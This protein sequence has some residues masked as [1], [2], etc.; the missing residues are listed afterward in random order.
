MLRKMHGLPVLFAGLL[1]IVLTISGAVLSLAPAIER[2]A[3][4]IPAAG[5][6][7]VAQLAERVVTH[8][9]GVEQIERRPSGEVIVYFSADG[10]AGADLVDPL[11]GQAVAPYRPSALFRWVTDLHRAFLLNDAGRM[12]V[13]VM[14]ALMVLISVSGLFLL[15]RRAGGWLN[16]FRPFT[17]SG[18]SRIHAELARFAVLGL[19]LSALTGSYLSAVRFGLLPEGESPEPSFP[20]QVS[21]GQPAPVGGLI[22]L[23]GLDLGELQELVF[24]YPDDVQDVYSLTTKQGAGFVD[25]S[26]GELLQYQQRSANN[27]FQQWMVRLHTGEGLWWLAL[28][29]GLAALTV[30]VLSFTGLQL[31]WQRR[32]SLQNHPCNTDVTLAD[33]IILVGSEGNNTW[34]F[35]TAL[36]RS[37]IKAGRSVHCADMNSLAGHYPQASIVFVLT[38][39]YGDGG[40]PAS[41]SQFMTALQTFRAPESLR[42]AVLGFGD[43]HYPK[44]CQFALEV[45]A[46]L[47]S[48]GIKRLH[49]T[50]LI[51][52]CSTEQFNAWGNTLGPLIGTSL[53]LDYQ[54]TSIPGITLELIERADYGIAVQAPTSIF[55]FKV[56]ADSRRWWH[57]LAMHKIQALPV[58][59]AGDLLG[60]LPPGD[61]SARFYSLASS[62]TDG[63]LE[64][65]VRKQPGG[66]CSGYLH[67]LKPGDRI[68]GFIRSNPGFRPATGQAPVILIGAGAGI[69]PLAGFIRKNT[70]HQ[71]M[72]LYWGGRNAQSDFLYQPELAGYLND[73]RLTALSTAFSRAAD[74]AYVQDKII[75]DQ[76]VVR[77][78]IEAGAQILVC[79]GR[80]M[81]ESVKQVIDDILQPMHTNVAELKAEGRYLEDVY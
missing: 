18:R 14:A 6:V 38:S 37:L 21:G 65:C 74:S 45:D 58:F 30:P 29:L 46:A 57:S 64:I 81:A 4:V 77:H 24:P 27:A 19:L 54:P 28:L 32:R 73:Q 7:T 22:A 72:F 43:R 5:D 39:T 55:R 12:L 56:L 67:D 78:M 13:G 63:V 16:L 79:G 71:P 80:R 26:T 44:F 69:G 33:T 9:P 20:A 61:H 31:W 70:Q 23:T 2:S 8:Y 25:Q 49:A 11:T 17:G 3:A 59:E 41:A 60:V 40:A 68:T 52:R 66:L 15:V 34:G 10:E 76:V 1:L 51:D 42:F 53:L 75:E 48:K 62:S 50:T 35:A 36:H 47:S